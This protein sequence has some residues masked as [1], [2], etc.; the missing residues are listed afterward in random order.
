MGIFFFVLRM[1]AEFVTQWQPRT[2]RWSVVC[3]INII[4]F[5]SFCFLGWQTVLLWCCSQ[6]HQNM[7]TNL[8]LLKKQCIIECSQAVILQAGFTAWLDVWSCFLQNFSITSLLQA[9]FKHASCYISDNYIA[10]F[11][12]QI[13]NLDP[14]L[15]SSVSCNTGRLSAWK[16]PACHLQ[17][18]KKL[19]SVSS[20]IPRLGSR[21]LASQLTSVVAFWT[22][23]LPVLQPRPENVQ[24]Q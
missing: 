18:G 3:S 16:P 1:S 5:L 8:C 21:D 23:C 15:L 13:S 2:D 4:I 6:T 11:W 17:K 9:N 24:P 12:K 14:R 7:R 10:F 20:A 19:S 22:A